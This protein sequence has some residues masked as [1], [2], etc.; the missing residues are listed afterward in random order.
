MLYRSLKPYIDTLNASKRSLKELETRYAGLELLEPPISSYDSSLPVDA[1][2][3]HSERQMSFLID[4][5]YSK[6]SV[7][8]LDNRVE[9][10]RKLLSDSENVYYAALNRFDSVD[11]KWVYRPEELEAEIKSTAGIVS[12]EEVAEWF[13]PKIPLER[14]I[15][16]GALKYVS[17]GFTLQVA[18]EN[19]VEHRVTALLPDGA[20][21]ALSDRFSNSMVDFGS[22]KGNRFQMDLEVTK[23]NEIKY[24]GG[25]ESPSSFESKARNF[26]RSTLGREI[27]S[28]IA[29]DS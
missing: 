20:A 9:E 10:L 8:E 17:E 2:L 28:K 11:S 29:A 6:K 22:L 4:I 3:K 19:D 14:E 15:Q 7:N 21:K 23:N 5:P 16:D 13:K 27:A 12:A 26:F 18:T 25:S 24:P 1:V